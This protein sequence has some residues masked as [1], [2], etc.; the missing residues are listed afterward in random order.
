MF[1][2]ALQ[3]VYTFLPYNLAIESEQQFKFDFS[4]YNKLLDALYPG[5]LLR[6]N[7]AATG[8]ISSEK[9]KS[10]FSF[11]F[12]LLR[13]QEVE[14]ESVRF[15]LDTNNPLYNTFLSAGRLTHPKHVLEDFNMISTTLK[16]TLF[17]RAEGKRPS[18]GLNE[19]ELNF[20]HVLESGVSYFGIK[21]SKLQQKDNDWIV[22]PLDTKEQL[23]FDPKENT[24]ELNQLTIASGDQSVLLK[25][26]YQSPESLS[27]NVQAMNIGLDNFL[28]G[29]KFQIKGKGDLTF[30]F[31]RSPEQ[32]GMYLKGSIQDLTANNRYVGNLTL[33]SQGNTQIHSYLFDVAIE[34]SIQQTLIGSGSVVGVIAY[35]QYGY[36]IECVRLIVFIS[37][38]KR[39]CKGCARKGKWQCK[40]VGHC[41][42]TME[43]QWECT[44][45]R[46]C[47]Y[48][49]LFECCLLRSA[50]F[51]TLTQSNI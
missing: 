40:C 33:N 39:Q 22:N 11:D 24:L 2:N 13:Y 15:Q 27:L 26:M 47:T 41:S 17:F 42:R 14:A 46:T 34:D 12:P 18:D 31:E 21:K 19:L 3:E 6:G 30:D 43:S 49:S 50:I 36:G 8:N 16:D 9:A 29:S 35:N 7:W 44:H 48:H 1:N 10:Q 32:N 20:Y 25:G 4:V 28:S 51:R 37:F 45:R 38:K 5:L 23:S